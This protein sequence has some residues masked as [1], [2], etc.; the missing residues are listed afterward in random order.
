M[1]AST[2]LAMALIESDPAPPYP[3]PPP[4]VVTPAAAVILTMNGD[5]EAT[6]EMPAVS[7]VTSES[8]MKAATA[9]LTRL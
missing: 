9:S 8:S 2:E 1:W 5:D 3:S 4:L 7:D 6:T